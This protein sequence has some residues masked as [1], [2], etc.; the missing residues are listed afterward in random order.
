MSGNHN[1]FGGAPIKGEGQSVYTEEELAPYKGQVETTYVERRV[2]MHLEG[3]VHRLID[4]FLKE[5]GYDPEE[6]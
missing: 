6:I 5:R 2:P 3:R 4:K 1:M